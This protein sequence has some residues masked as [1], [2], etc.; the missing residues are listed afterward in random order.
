MEYTPRTV[1]LV[2]IF[3][4]ISGGGGFYLGSMTKPTLPRESV[5][6]SKGSVN[7]TPA[8][9]IPTKTSVP[10]PAT[11]SASPNVSSK[12]ATPVATSSAKTSSPSASPKA[13]TNSAKTSTPSASGSSQVQGVQTGPAE[14]APTIKKSPSGSF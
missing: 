8:S 3:S 12:S 4:L 7:V 1:L 13:A 2:L 9:P 14:T 11:S 5:T 10:N 6:D